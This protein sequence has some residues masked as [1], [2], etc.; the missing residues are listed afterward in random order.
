MSDRK[1]EQAV[2]KICELGCI[3][4]NTVISDLSSNKIS[5]LTRSFSSSQR[6]AILKELDEIMA[7]YDKPCNLAI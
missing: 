5:D 7:V 4:V 1:V 3:K 2:E 6:K